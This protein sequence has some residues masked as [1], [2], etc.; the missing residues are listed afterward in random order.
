M[1]RPLGDILSSIAHDIIELTVVVLSIIVRLSA[2]TAPLQ[3]LWQHRSSAVQARLRRNN[4][5]FATLDGS[6]QAS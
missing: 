6:L 3:A 1:S 5:I 4:V 2:E